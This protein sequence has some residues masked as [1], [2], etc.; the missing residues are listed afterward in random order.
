M[1]IINLFSRETLTTDITEVLGAVLLPPLLGLESCDLHACKWILR[2]LK[3]TMIKML[4][5]VKS[6]FR[7]VF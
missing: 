4:K 3:Q 7:E 1:E 2:H 5:D 6:W